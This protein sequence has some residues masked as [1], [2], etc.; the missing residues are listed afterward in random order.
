MFR[1]NSDSVKYCSVDIKLHG[2]G[3]RKLC[4]LH[5]NLLIV[6]KCKPDLVFIQIRHKFATFTQHDI[7]CTAAERIKLVKDVK[8]MSVSTI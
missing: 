3:G 5:F 2:V 1:T 7:Q 4:L 8:C 6:K